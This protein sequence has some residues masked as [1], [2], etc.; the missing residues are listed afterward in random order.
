MLFRSEPSVRDWQRALGERYRPSTLVLGIPDTV[1]GP[2]PALLAKPSGSLQAGGV[3]AWVCEGVTCL[4][5]VHALEALLDV[6]D[7]ADRKSRAG[8]AG[9]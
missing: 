8:D 7:G 9:L 4:A 2:L 3:N 6:L 5:P 1:D